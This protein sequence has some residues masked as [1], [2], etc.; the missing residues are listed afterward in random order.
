MLRA[1]IAAEREERVRRESLSSPAPVPSRAIPDSTQPADS[2]ITFD[3]Q[4]TVPTTEPLPPTEVEQP[5]T[6]SETPRSTLSA[7]LVSHAGAM[8]P[9]LRSSSA[10][11]PTGRI[12][13]R[14]TARDAGQQLSGIGVA[15]Y[16]SFGRLADWRTTDAAG[17]YVS[18]TLPAGGY[19]VVAHRNY[20]WQDTIVRDFAITKYTRVRVRH[21]ASFRFSTGTLLEADGG[22]FYFGFFNDS[23]QFWA[24][25]DPQRGVM[26]LG[27]I[28]STPLEVIAPPSPACEGANVWQVVAPTSCYSRGAVAAVP[29]HTYV[30]VPR[31]GEPNGFIVFRVVDVQPGLWVDLEYL[32][33]GGAA[34]GE[35]I[36]VNDGAITTGIDQSL[37]AV[38]SIFGITP[39]RGPVDGGTLV[40][41]TGVNFQ[42][43][44]VVTFD[45]LPAGDVTVVSPTLV[46]ASTPASGG[47]AV[48]VEV[49]NPDGTSGAAVSGYRYDMPAPG[50]FDKSF[51]SAQQPIADPVVT[52]RWQPSVNAIAYQICVDTVD[53]DTC[54]AAASLT[55]GWAPVG[56]VTLVSWPRSQFVPGTTYYWQARA[57]NTNGVTDADG[58][59]WSRFGVATVS[60]AELITPASGATF[61]ASEVRFAW[62]PGTDVAAYHLAI[63]TA[64]GADDL[65]SSVTTALS[66]TVALPYDGRAIH[67]R[68]GSLI[69]GDWLC[70]DYVFTAARIDRPRL[71][72]GEGG[73]N[74]GG[75][76]RPLP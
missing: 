3:A 19:Q 74:A 58:G 6:D 39:R 61:T 15:I 27:D 37:A 51:T 11:K 29:G 73:P 53:D 31:R 5:R 41:I 59:S 47:G 10:V 13:G 21:G 30:A 75:P 64:P 9:N 69:G 43:G 4:I 35:P 70:R 28:R 26:A 23:P 55:S 38:P 48:D 2:Q 33:T 32:V 24:N 22:D 1:P 60:I 52:L 57:L 14:I 18:G 67:V 56:D 76:P 66:T 12:S 45:G 36:A 7:D 40:T 50:A 71:G 65:V 49:W 25:H 8:V 20:G 46:V 34:R 72:L 68:L 16:D 62:T 54:T 44:A 17:D 63:G 42:D